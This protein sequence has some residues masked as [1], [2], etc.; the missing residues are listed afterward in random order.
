MACEE[1]GWV[2]RFSQFIDK[3]SKGNYKYT[4]GYEK[5]LI[6]FKLFDKKGRLLPQ[7]AVEPRFDNEFNK[8]ILDK[9]VEGEKSKVPYDELYDKVKEGLGLNKTRAEEMAEKYAF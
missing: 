3:D 4:P 9:Y 6:D 5:L 2:P 8:Q 7:E 1:K